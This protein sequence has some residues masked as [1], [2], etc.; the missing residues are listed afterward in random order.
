MCDIENVMKI[1]GW[2]WKWWQ[3]SC[4]TLKV[5]SKIGVWRWKLCQNSC[6]ILKMIPRVG[7]WHW[8]WWWCPRLFQGR[9]FA[10]ARKKGTKQALWGKQEASQ[11]FTIIS[12]YGH[13]LFIIW[14]SFIYILKLDF[15]SQLPLIIVT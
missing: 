1:G 12:N 10:L 13:S 2:Y 15:K 11:Y 7:V 3:N 5:I 14:L 6:L 4:L 9:F 8:K